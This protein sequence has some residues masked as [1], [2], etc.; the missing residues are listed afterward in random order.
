LEVERTE[1]PDINQLIARH[2]SRYHL[3]AFLARPG[4][5][6]LDFPCG[7]GYGSELLGYV[8]Y[9][10]MDN[11]PVT[12]EYANLFYEC[13][14]RGFY[15]GDLTK[16]NID[17]NYDLILCIDGPEH[18]KREYQ[19]SLIETFY[20]SLNPGGTLLTS[21]PETKESGSSAINQ[22]HL[23]ELTFDDFSSLL[24]KEF[25]DVQIIKHED[26]LHN[27]VK[28]NCMYAIARRGND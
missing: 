11:D 16:P 2:K 1:L 23:G 10:G 21:M 18:I 6:V 27:G 8:N 7:S 20:H 22:Y 13:E 14:G 3:G 24:H 12:I 28:T 5:K 26:T 4:M 9:T 19:A 15:V 25:D 17:D